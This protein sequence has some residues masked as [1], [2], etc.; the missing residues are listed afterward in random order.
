VFATEYAPLAP[1]LL[2]CTAV[3]HHGGVGTIALALKAGTPML[4]MPH[5]H[6]Q[7][8]NAVRARRLGSSRMLWRHQYHAPRVAA[9]LRALLSDGRYYQRA[10]KIRQ[11]LQAEDGTR[12]ACDEIE[13]QLQV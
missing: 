1:L 11:Q 5:A 7:I 4:M 2:R 13:R 10:Q 8:E 9:E 6:D 12:Q 3:V